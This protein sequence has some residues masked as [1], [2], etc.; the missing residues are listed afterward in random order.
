MPCIQGS[1][2]A[3]RGSVQG[4]WATLNRQILP[5]ETS[6]YLIQR[7]LKGLAMYH[8]TC[9]D[10][11]G[12]RALFNPGLGTLEIAIVECHGSPVSEKNPLYEA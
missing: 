11:P 3:T 9:L 2:E 1:R 7:H 12:F 4:V 8:L 6:L 10:L 5:R